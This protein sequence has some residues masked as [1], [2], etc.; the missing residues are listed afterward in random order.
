MLGQTLSGG[1][2]VKSAEAIKTFL[3]RHIESVEKLEVLL[4]LKM[5]RDREW[6]AIEI[7]NEIKTHPES[8]RNR[9]LGLCE[10]ELL[11]RRLDHKLERYQYAPKSEDLDKLINGLQHLYKE[12]RV[13]VI[14]LIFPTQ[15]QK[16]RRFADAFDLRRNSSGDSSDE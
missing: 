14:E 3:V 11:A 5:H 4:L 13:Y 12:R 10:I 7:S 9:L 16:A 6:T 1:E 2:K 15:T 8:V